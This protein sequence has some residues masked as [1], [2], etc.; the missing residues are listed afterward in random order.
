MPA[1]GDI[2]FVLVGVLLL[3]YALLDGFD[4]GAGILHPFV[5]R[6]DPE[7]RAVMRSIG[8]VW[9]GNEVWLL[10]AGGALFAAFPMVYATVFSGFYLALILLLA[11]L[12][13]RAVAL[14]FRDQLPGTGW[15]RAWDVA[16][17]LG[18]LLPALLLGVAVGNIVRGLPL[19]AD[20]L[21]HGGLVGL[22][23]PLPL[24]IGLLVVAFTITHGAAWLL[25]KN[26][27]PIAARSRAAA[28]GG[29]LALA[30]LWLAA[31]L[32]AWALAPDRWE[33]FGSPLAWLAPGVVVV[34]LVA[35]PVLVRAG[36]AGLALVASGL[37]MAGMIATLGIGLY[38]NLVPAL[39]T[40]ERSL[41]ISNAASSQLTLGVMLGIA[42]VGVPIVLA[43]TAAIYWRFRGVVRLDEEGYGH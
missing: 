13:F 18:S 10:T 20:G 30:I 41:T 28:L 1:L 21:Y 14:E 34:G 7:R 29:W 25:L 32:A 39:D 27:G 37:S 2:W 36:R 4:L 31:T 3:G 33:P 38:P 22:L 24:V 15:R 17:F 6:T 9:D 23:T 19:D 40:P 5:A 16:F 11:A 12:I 43:Y 8:P 42:L 35:F 26:E